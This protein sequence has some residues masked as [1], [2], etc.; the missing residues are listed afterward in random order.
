MSIRDRALVFGIG[1]YLTLGAKRTPINLLGP[2]RDATDMAD[3]LRSQGAHV[4]LVT[5]DG[6]GASAYSVTDLRPEFGDVE[7]PFS[8]LVQDAG[9]LFENGRRVYL[10]SRLTVYVAGHGFIPDPKHLALITAESSSYQKMGIQVTSWADWFSR[11]T[12]FDEIVVYMD[13]CTAADYAQTARGPVAQAFSPRS[14]GLAKLV[15]VWAAPPDQ[16]AYER[17]DETGVV[18]GLFTAELLKAL[19]GAAA[20]SNG[21]VTTSSLRR[22]FES[23]GIA[24]T[25]KTDTGD[26][27]LKPHFRDSDE[28]VLASVPAPIQIT[29]HTGLEPPA[30]VTID[31]PHGAVFSG[32][33]GPEGRV[34][35]PALAGIYALRTSIG[36]KY[37]E[38]GAGGQSDVHPH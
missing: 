8:K 17:E 2:V 16:L 21:D 19:T 7:R 15:T 37:F 9:D 5:S 10:G 12:P 31:G 25:D 1:R 4:T 29:V 14:S 34:Q 20:D 28:L 26:I 11:Q 3:W 33:V 30:A 6:D 35:I 23:S 22:Y 18:R 27:R 24:G 32:A 38:I 36:A 13:C